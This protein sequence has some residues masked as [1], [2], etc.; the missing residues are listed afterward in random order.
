MAIELN[1][2]LTNPKRNEAKSIDFR[3]LKSTKKKNM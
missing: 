1:T 2:C 3:N